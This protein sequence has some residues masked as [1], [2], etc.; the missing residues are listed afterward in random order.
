MRQCS[1]RTSITNNFPIFD[2]MTGNFQDFYSIL[3][4][5]AME[6]VS[7]TLSNI[8]VR[9]Y[10]ISQMKSFGWIVEATNFQEY[11][12]F[13]YKTFSNIVCT[14]P[15]GVNFAN[16]NLNQDFQKKDLVLK[17]RIVL[18][19]HFDSKFFENFKFVGATDSAVSCSLLIDIAKFLNENYKI[20]NFS[21]SK[22]HLQFIFFDGEEA[23]KEWSRTDSIYG[24]RHYASTLKN[25][26]QQ[27]AF[28]SIDL[29]ILLDLI[30][31]DNCQFP[32][33]FPRSTSNC[34]DLLSRIERHLRNKN[35]L[36]KKTQYYFRGHYGLFGVDDDHT[37]FLNENVPIIH[38]V[39]FPFPTQWHTAKDNIENLNKSNIHDMRI[40]LKC[41][42]LELLNSDKKSEKF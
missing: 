22:R 21:K 4:E 25:D 3:K 20:E 18:A 26:F 40:I 39:P 37:P 8:S 23:F 16:K 33:F 28:D 27:D 34:Y 7:G 30:G 36:K 38:L 1:I 10:I 6:R 2:N 31:A 24:S 35:M 17:N 5:I 12:P 9:N 13:G 11:T 19:C 14:Y 15:I 42:L 41:F 32:N 29:F